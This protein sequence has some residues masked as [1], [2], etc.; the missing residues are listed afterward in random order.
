[1]IID[2]WDRDGSG[3]YADL[4][5]TYQTLQN[6][7]GLNWVGFPESAEY[8]QLLPLPVIEDRGRYW[9]ALNEDEFAKIARMANE[10]GLKF[11][12]HGGN[13][14]IGPKIA[15][16]L[17]TDNPFGW[18][19]HNISEADS[20]WWDE[21]F[22]Q[23]GNFL[24]PKAIMAETNGVEMFSLG[25]HL[26]YVDTDYNA[27]RWTNLVNRIRG[28]YSGKL[29]YFALNYLGP[30]P[31]W[32][33]H[34]DYIGVFMGRPI[35]TNGDPSLAELV[36]GISGF[37][38][39]VQHPKPVIFYL[40][41]A[42]IDSAAMGIGAPDINEPTA[43]L[44]IDFQ[45]QADIYEAFF[46]VMMEREWIAGCLSW[47]Y[48]YFDNYFYYPDP[49]VDEDMRFTSSI[50]NKLA[51][52]VTFKWRYTFDSTAVPVNVPPT[53]AN[54][55]QNFVLFQNYPNPFNP[56]TTI[57]YQL[58]RPGRVT[59][60][61]YNLMGQEIQMLADK[62]QETG[63]HKIE[64]DGINNQGLMVSTGLYVVRITTDDFTHSK[65]I[66]LIR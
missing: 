18:V 45:E 55:P 36:A 52:A 16:S 10:K 30:N 8:S 2:F 40:D 47:N 7:S 12:F 53:V 1:V 46:Q 23:W 26:D 49:N 48:A 15:D 63:V 3:N 44:S 59:L 27:T 5:E 58:H 22:N 28:V 14:G 25:A 38:D 51:E 20:S 42:S 32:A 62:V 19:P 13:P 31:G 56:K 60:K 21:W 34:L 64:W 41:F 33:S 37:V 61:V 66:V 65:K 29:V 11:Y 17:G 39:E 35:A 54:T 9:R 43:H 6:R 57:Q 50:R 24:E 4:A